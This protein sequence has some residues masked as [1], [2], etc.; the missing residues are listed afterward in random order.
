LVVT[1][2]DLLRSKKKRQDPG[3]EEDEEDFESFNSIELTKTSFSK[4]QKT[5]STP[6]DST[7][8]QV[9]PQ[10]LIEEVKE[11]P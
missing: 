2:L 8:P 6:A 10:P 11:E 3:P 7:P 5:D 9:E 4:Y 1:L